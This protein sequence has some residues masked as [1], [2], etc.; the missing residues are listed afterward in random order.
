MGKPIPMMFA[1][2]WAGLLVAVAVQYHGSYNGDQEWIL[3]FTRLWLDGRTLYD[4]LFSALPP[5]I[6]W[7]YALPVRISAWWG[8]SDA[9]VLALL[10]LLTC[11]LSI[12]LCVRLL[13]ATEGFRSPA[14]RRFLT[15]L[16]AYM[17][18]VWTSAQ[19]F[20][21]REHIFYVLTFPYL[22]RWMPSVAGLPLSRRMRAVLGVLA[23][24]GFCIKPNCAFVF[25]G[26][27]AL[28]IARTRRL[29]HLWSL[30]NLLICAIAALYLLMVALYAPQYY[31]L[32]LPMALLTY[33]AAGDPTAWWFYVP[34]ACVVAGISLADFRWRAHSPY[35]RDIHYLFGLNT[36]FL[37]YAL[38]T[39]GWAYTWNPLFCTLLLLNGFIW[40]EHRD[41]A[42]RTDVDDAV[43]RQSRKGQW[44]CLLNWGINTAIV[45]AL[46]YADT[47]DF[48]G[49][50]QNKCPID[51]AL[52][53]AVLREE[54]VHTFGVISTRLQLWPTL[55][56][57][58]GTHQVTRFNHLWM[59]PKFYIE[60]AQFAQKHGWILEYI[61]QGYADDLERY[62]P[63]LVFVDDS[64]F[65]IDIYH[66]IDLV[67]FMS[68]NTRFKEAWSHYQLARSV[69]QCAVLPSSIK[70]VTKENSVK[71]HCK[72]LIYR[73]K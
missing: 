1:L 61:R 6:F 11:A 3:Y 2:A 23:G 30:E 25:I 58:T 40:F 13:G 38:S 64:D 28:V 45:A 59:L 16:L 43:R 60:D 50:C 70:V 20:F 48:S 46:A 15:L 56:R 51:R 31:T 33:S 27:Q 63:D 54:D 69:N 10:G 21:D 4:G 41:D 37:L 47:P 72:Y 26:V 62:K 35:R 29:T 55:A 44:A 67:A 9:H 34:A 36:V 8:M 12:M 17:F 49:L 19:Y 42:A 24:I 65:Y 32:V 22:M 52:K 71:H 53:A 14:R 66:P 73:R 39:A 5:L 68:E 57:A 18:V 7:I